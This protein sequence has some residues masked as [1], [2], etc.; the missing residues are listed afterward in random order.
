MISQV[1]MP[2]NPW[3]Y[4]DSAGYAGSQVSG[5][6]AEGEQIFQTAGCSNCH[7][8]Q[9]GFYTDNQLHGRGAEYFRR[10]IERYLD[11][12][13]V[14]FNIAQA[15]LDANENLNG[16]QADS[17]EEV[18]LQ[19]PIDTFMPFGF[20]EE[21]ILFFQDP[22]AETP[23]SQAELDALFGQRKVGLEDNERGTIVGSTEGQVSVNTPTL[24]G[25]WWGNN[26]LRGGMAKT[27]REAISGPGHTQLRTD[28]VLLMNGAHPEL[29]GGERGWAF[30]ITGSYQA[31]GMT[32]SLSDEQLRALEYFVK[33][34]P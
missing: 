14:D 29:N 15:L 16:S 24:R 1:R 33:S 22:L 20:D 13:L 21:N 8:P 5:L 11:S 32:G 23:G 19:L 28:G 31:H 26:F 25:V 17:N 6:I 27:F 2:P 9:G 3:A 30:N 10:F 18:N 4:L 34:I 7:D 12:G